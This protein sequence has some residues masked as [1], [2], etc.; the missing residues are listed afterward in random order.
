MRVDLGALESTF[1]LLTC[2]DLLQK[3]NIP[4]KRNKT[5]FSNKEMNKDMVD[6]TFNIEY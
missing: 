1:F 4:N 2:V 5:H 3:Q 6:E